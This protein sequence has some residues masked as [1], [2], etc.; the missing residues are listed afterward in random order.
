[1]KAVAV[2]DGKISGRVEFTE[3]EVEGKKRVWIDAELKGFRPN[4]VHGFHVHE[5]GDMTLKC[6][7]MCAHFNPYGTVHG[8]AD[9]KVRHVGDL[10]NL[11]SNG[12]GVAVMRRFDRLIK[13]KPGALSIVGR[14][15]VIHEDEDD[16]GLGGDEE[17][18]N[19]GNAGKRIACAVIG[20]AKS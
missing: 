15:L 6:D 9:S 10:G 20:I 1:M 19:T 7:S 16:L 2:F 4:T 3:V 17:S 11:V 5:C 12:R 8:G 18:L 14:G 13:V